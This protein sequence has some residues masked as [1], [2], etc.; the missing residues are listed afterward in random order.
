M[1]HSVLLFILLLLLFWI[2][3]EWIHKEDSLYGNVI[4]D[5]GVSALGDTLKVNTTLTSLKYVHVIAMD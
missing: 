4:T 1:F 5:A 2:D 3:D